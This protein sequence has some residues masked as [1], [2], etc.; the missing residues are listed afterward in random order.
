MG[1]LVDVVDNN[2]N[3]NDDDGDAVVESE[4]SELV[5]NNSV[6]MADA[7]TEEE[8]GGVG[9]EKLER[10]EGVDG[11]DGEIFPGFYQAIVEVHPT[12]KT[13]QNSIDGFDYNPEIELTNG[14]NYDSDDEESE[15][16]SQSVEEDGYETDDYTF[17]EISVYEI[18]EVAG[19][20]F[21]VAEE[22]DQLVE[23]V[24]VL[25]ELS[26][27]KDDSEKNNEINSV[28]ELANGNDRKG[29]E[30]TNPILCK[31]NGKS[32]GRR[33]RGISGSRRKQRNRQRR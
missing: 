20:R 28:T 11:D 9:R 18:Q 3:N 10:N 23:C 30:L 2:N 22:K 25:T 17:V 13:E 29:S 24:A 1:G 32:K 6:T 33:R 7:E 8:G 15:I 27:D 21:Q 31:L 19:P 4:C 26:T 12:R 16:V 5:E 14:T